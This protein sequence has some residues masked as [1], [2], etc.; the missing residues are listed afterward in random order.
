MRVAISAH[1]T[2]GDVEPAV[3]VG[4]RLAQRGHE[5]AVA[6]SRPWSGK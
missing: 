4:D 3:A 5:V 1:G 6:G 2:R